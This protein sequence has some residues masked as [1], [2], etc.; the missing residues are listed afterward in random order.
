MAR[1]KIAE[2]YH[3]RLAQEVLDYHARG[4]VLFLSK[5]TAGKLK[6]LTAPS[7]Y[8]AWSSSI[9]EKDFEKLQLATGHL[10]GIDSGSLQK[11]LGELEALIEKDLNLE[12]I[13]KE[14]RKLES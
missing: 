2:D 12:R 8:Y 7:R 5:A 13:S 9:S 1:R 14:A 6:D 4:D 3:V 10:S 11:A